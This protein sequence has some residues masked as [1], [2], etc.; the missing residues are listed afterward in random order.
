MDA[1]AVDPEPLIVP[2]AVANFDK[3]LTQATTAA[4]V[5]PAF[6]LSDRVADPDNKDAMLD[7]ANRL[8]ADYR[9]YVQQAI[10]LANS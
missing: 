4:I 7:F 9:D 3:R 10:A 5:F 1:A 2:I 6:R 8:Q